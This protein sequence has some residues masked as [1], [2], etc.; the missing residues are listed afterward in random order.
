[1]IEQDVV[2]PDGRILRIREAGDPRGK[3][4]FTLHG[5]PGSRLLYEPHVRDATRRGIRLI[6]YDRPGYGG[7]T[8][9]AGRNV[10]DA[11]R[12]VRAIADALGIE[13]L[14]VWG[15]STGGAP[16]LACAALL[17]G[18]V[19]AAASLAALAPYPAEGLDWFEGMGD[20][21]RLG[22]QRIIADRAAWASY[23]NLTVETASN[24]ERLI[25]E[26]SPL[27]SEVDRTALDTELATFFVNQIREGLRPSIAGDIDDQLAQT[28]PWGFDFTTIRVPLQYWHGEQDRFFPVSHGRWLAARLPRAEVHIEPHDGHLT[29]FTQR[30]PAVHEWLVSKF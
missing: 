23:A 20:T 28:L 11:A 26:F 25:E 22:F 9:N 10:A 12:D 7:S 14:A 5:N 21:N 29:L 13:R 16:A 4:V 27:L 24:P 15:I 8:R 30:I 18:R 2:L 6:G 1:M 19:V 3:P 17:S